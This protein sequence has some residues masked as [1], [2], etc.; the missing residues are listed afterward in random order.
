M[1]SHRLQCRGANFLVDW[2]L[3]GIVVAGVA[4]A[5]VA[6]CGSHP[7][8]S[9]GGNGP[10]P[11]VVINEAVLGVAVADLNGDGRPDVAITT[12]TG[13]AGGVG[14]YLHTPV[15]GKGY[16]ERVDYPAS[17]NPFTIL[18]ADVNGDGIPD[19]VTT[20]GTTGL[21]MVF[22]NAATAP[23]TFGAPQTI[24]VPGV[25]YAAIA[26]M[27]GDG[28][29]DLVVAGNGLMLLPQTVGT[30]GTFG[31]ATTLLTGSATIHSVAVGDLNGDGT[32]DIA[33]ADDDGVTVVFMKSLNGIV[34]VASTASVYTNTKHGAFPAI[35]I[36]DID[37]DGRNDLVIADTIG[38]SITILLQ[39]PGTS[40]QFLPPVRYAL[41]AGTGLSVVVADLNGDGHPDLV[42]GGSA[43]LSVLLQDPT[44][45]GAF[46]IATTYLAPLGANAL[47]VA[48]INGDG[49]PD[50]VTESGTSSTVVNDLLRT[51]PGVLYQDPSNPGSFQPLENLK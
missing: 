30:P 48:D 11:T 1:H 47:A 28:F 21:V 6:G 42:C 33:L 9:P 46:P 12:T 51:P 29:P 17:T 14:V 39:S 7:C 44:H 24:S 27:N 10:C 15:V 13:G 4:A 18:A 45:P 8:L 23:G 40:G 26:D 19:L 49:L 50:I 5:P 31:P 16:A 22:L 2:R 36:F 25:N 3:A 35:A 32:P 41:P 20:D 38:G 43:R 37:G 34:T